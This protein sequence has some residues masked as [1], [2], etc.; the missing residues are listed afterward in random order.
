MRCLPA[1]TQPINSAVHLLQPCGHLLC[2]E[3]WTALLDR[4]GEKCPVTQ[5]VIGGSCTLPETTYLSMTPLRARAAQPRSLRPRPVAELVARR[6]RVLEVADE[7]SVETGEESNGQIPRGLQR[8][9]L[10][11]ISLL[12]PWGT[13]SLALK[14]VRR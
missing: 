2:G 3:C 12:W 4:G 13:T 9:N 11:G 8:F 5:T 1:D 10:D 7:M 6:R 14:Y